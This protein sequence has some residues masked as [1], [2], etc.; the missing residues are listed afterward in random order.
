MD[1]AEM[2][3]W[4]LPCCGVGYYSRRFVWV[5]NDDCEYL[6]ECACGAVFTLERTYE[7]PGEWLS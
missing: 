7:W 1:D 4:R 3:T 6:V 2:Y 5:E